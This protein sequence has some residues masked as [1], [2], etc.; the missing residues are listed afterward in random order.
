MS[1]KRKP[2]RDRALAGEITNKGSRTVQVHERIE[3]YTIAKRRQDT[4][5]NHLRD[6]SSGAVKQEQY[7]VFDLKKTI[8]AISGCFNYLVFHDY[9]RIGETRLV[10]ATSCKKHL[11]CAPCAIRR[12]GKTVKSYHAKYNEIIAHRA[13][14]KPYLLTLTVK[15]GHDLE[16]RFNHLVKCQKALLKSRRNYLKRGN[17]FNEFCKI[18][19]AVYSSELTKSEHGWHPHLHMVVLVPENNPIDFDFKNPKNSKLSKDWHNITGDSFVVDIRPLHDDPVTGFVEV[20]KYA[21]KFS[22]LTAHDTVQAFSLLRGKR[23]Q[24]SF[25]CFRGVEVP[26][27]LNEDAIEDEPYIELIYKYVSQNFTLTSHKQVDL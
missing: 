6:I 27:E 9:Y 26:T 7:G 5:L 11:L 8:S 12:A 17:G 15:N 14:L 22:E 3:K 21:L 16:E 10:Q 25:G 24:G 1:E 23:L 2:L 13:N 18:E 19:G 20:F 4:I